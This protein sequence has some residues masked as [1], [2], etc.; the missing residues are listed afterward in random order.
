MRTTLSIDDSLIGQLLEQTKATSKNKAIIL[1]ITEYLRKQ[2][3]EKILSYE[4]Q[5]VI[6]D[7][8]QELEEQE[9]QENG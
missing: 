8:W 5:L 4:G 2:K 7:N 6:E 9:L 1:A 3:L